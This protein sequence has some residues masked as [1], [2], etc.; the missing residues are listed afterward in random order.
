MLE[1][2]FYLHAISPRVVYHVHSFGVLALLHHASL[3]AD[4]TCVSLDHAR[5][6]IHRA[7]TL[8]HFSPNTCSPP[9]SLCAQSCIASLNYLLNMCWRVRCMSPALPFLSLVASLPIRTRLALLFYVR[10]SCGCCPPSA[11]RRVSLCPPPPPP[12]ALDAFLV[13]LDILG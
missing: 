11:S 2:P 12:Y 5:H 7:S 13:R 1:L 8:P 9:S 10:F 4:S 3:S 6:G